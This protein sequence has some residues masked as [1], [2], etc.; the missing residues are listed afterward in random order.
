MTKKTAI[1]TFSQIKHFGLDIE[2]APAKELGQHEAAV[3]DYIEGKLA[4]AKAADPSMTYD[5]FASLHPSFGQVV[6]VSVGYVG[7]T[8]NG[9]PAMALK[10]YTGSE[11]ELLEAFA[12][13]AAPFRGV[14]VHYNGRTFDVPFL[15]SR[16][17]H[18]R[19][20]GISP[21]FADLTYPNGSHH[22]D[23]LECHSLGDA[24]RRLPLGPLASPQG[25]PS[26]KSDMDGSKVADAFRQGEMARIARYCESDV[27]TVLN[28]QRV[29]VDH[30]DPVPSLNLYSVDSDGEYLQL[31]GARPDGSCPSAWYGDN[32]LYLPPRAGDGAQRVGETV[33]R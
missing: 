19:I 4:R 32:C 10:S 18:H 9:E 30:V 6:C 17:R 28:L 5:K 11:P 26:P 31:A 7:E 14:W 33:R 22:L 27:A 24:S 2:T 25:L 1:T 3:R 16:M 21:W 12:R 29:L 23:L 13:I 15:L 8:A 20:R